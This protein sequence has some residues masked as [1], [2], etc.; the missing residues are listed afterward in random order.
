MASQIYDSWE[1]FFEKFWADKNWNKWRKAPLVE[2]Y[3]VGLT[4]G[5][6]LLFYFHINFINY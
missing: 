2:V 3:G 4:E 5:G 1:V 6:V